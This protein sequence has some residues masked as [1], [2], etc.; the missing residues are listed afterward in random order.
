MTNPR[1]RVTINGGGRLRG[2]LTLPG[3]KSIS[4]RALILSAV[5]EGRSRIRNL[6]PGQD[7]T[8]T[9]SAIQALGAE[10]DRRDDGEIIVMGQGLDGLREPDNVIDVGNSGTTIRMMTGLLAGRPGFA[11]LTGDESIRKRPMLRVVE[12]LRRM[13]AMIQG[14]KGGELPPLAI[15]G[16][17]LDT[18]DYDLPVAS[19][20]VKSAL[21]LAALAVRG[22][23]V[24]REPGAS[25][26]HTERMLGH[27]GAPVESVEG[28]V[29]L[30]GPKQ[31][32]GGEIDVPGDI[33]SAAFFMILA[34]LLPG[35]ELRIRNVGVNPTRTGAVE[36]L[37]RMGGAIELI[38]PREVSGEPV[39]DIVV[40]SGELKGTEIRAPEIPRTID[41]LPV[42]AVAA[43][44]ATGVT[45]IRDA[46]ELR[47]KESDRIRA[48]VELLR[49]FGANVEE[50][51]DGMTIE[52]SGELEG[53]HCRAVNDHRIAMASVVAGILAK[54]TTTVD[55]IQWVDVSFPGFLDVV[56][57][58]RVGRP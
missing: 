38:D 31:V 17:A 47:V 32:R 13:G 30:T 22:E 55:G 11:V 9:K 19:A 7:V 14:R 2:E 39:A 10:V 4:H 57:R 52:G 34:L 41:E 8:R 53:A 27:L 6:S 44:K 42:I 54:G 20:Q 33:S 16:G 28:C 25:R 48:T 23:S 45:T 49:R 58:V 21:M 37:R 43:A 36:V 15:T 24:I 50:H 3:D 12:P 35:S 5:A 46:A 40:R 18:I 51:P 1:N 26:D 29:R 56:N